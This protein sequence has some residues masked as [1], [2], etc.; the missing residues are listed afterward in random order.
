MASLAS[1]E[2]A[3]MA[4]WTRAVPGMLCV[5]SGVQGVGLLLPAFPFCGIVIPVV[6]KAGM[7][8]SASS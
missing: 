6:Q 8:P 5:A 1:Q 2:R 7:L 3:L 4:Q